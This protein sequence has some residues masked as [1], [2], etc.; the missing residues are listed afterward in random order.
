MI[1]QTRRWIDYA[2]VR[3]IVNTMSV[4]NKELKEITGTVLDQASSVQLSHLILVFSTDLREDQGPDCGYDREP[5]E[6]G[7]SRCYEVGI[8]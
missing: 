7:W 5:R 1:T 3:N 2:E 8:L 6:G 4:D